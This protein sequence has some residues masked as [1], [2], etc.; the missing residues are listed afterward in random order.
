[1][2]R[3][4][5]VTD[6]ETTGVDPSTDRIVQIAIQCWT[7][8]GMTGEWK[9]LVDPGITEM[10]LGAFEAHGISVAQIKRCQD[11]DN[12]REMCTCLAFKVTPT[13]AQVAPVLARKF[14]NC[15]YAGK[16]VR[17]DLRMYAHEFQ[18]AGIAWDYKDARIVDGERLEQIAVPRTLSDLYLKYTGEQLI[19]AHDA[20]A[21]V[22]ASTAVIVGQ[23][24]KH[25]V[26][27]PRDLDTLH[28]LQWPG[29]LTTDGSF[30]MVKGVPTCSFGK[31]RGVPMSDIPSGYYNWL[32]KSDFAED[33]KEL[34]RDALY[35]KFPKERSLLP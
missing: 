34:C 2:T 23:L 10:P 13:F 30:R 9:S 8:E 15:D 28:E 31:H 1:L 14:S 12:P 18:L 25:H 29:W 19:D 33:V 7:P 24:L 6:T 4:L 32:I 16:N 17:F 3:P 11:C 27:L 21:D 22:R 35:G 20:M 5:Y 26:V